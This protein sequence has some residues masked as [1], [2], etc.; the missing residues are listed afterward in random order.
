MMSISSYN[1]EYNAKPWLNTTSNPP[2]PTA[3]GQGVP[4]TTSAIQSPIFT[5]QARGENRIATPTG[6]VQTRKPIVG[7][8]YGFYGKTSPPSSFAKF[9]ESWNTFI[10]SWANFKP[11]PASTPQEVDPYTMVQNPWMRPSSQS[12][13]N[14]YFFWEI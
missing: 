10:N 6:F 11:N 13:T 4:I 2:L 7:N 3:G 9:I 14:P 12:S 1:P 5:T 8:S